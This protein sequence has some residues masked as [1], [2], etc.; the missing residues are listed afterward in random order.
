[1][2]ARAYVEK[3]DD[4]WGLRKIGLQKRRSELIKTHINRGLILDVGC[5]FGIYSEFIR[6][7]GNAVISLDPSK[8]MVIDGKKLF[9]KLTFLRGCGEAL[10]FRENAFDSILCMGTLIYSKHRKQFLSELYRVLKSGGHLCLVERNRDSPMHAFIRRF[11]RNENA[12]DNPESFFSK[13]E[14]ETLL[15]KEGFVV[16]RVIGDH[17]SLPF[18]TQSTYRLAEIFPSLANF[19]VFECE[20][21]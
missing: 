3:S 13:N 15:R 4:P 9:D 18:F 12:V 21:K 7:L 1:M 16:K 11:R 17:I 10:P 20:K 19:L 8:R 14:L 2:D 6:K 5:G